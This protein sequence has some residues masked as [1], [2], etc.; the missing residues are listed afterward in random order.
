MEANNQ[1]NATEFVDIILD[2]DSEVTSSLHPID[3]S[4]DQTINEIK[5]ACTLEEPPISSHV[6]EPLTFRDA[7]DIVTTERAIPGKRVAMLFGINYIKSPQARLNGCI[8]DTYNVA[9]ML[10]TPRFAFDEVTVY[11]D[12]K[13]PAQVTMLGLVRNLQN[14]ALRSWSENLS[15]VWIH[16]S[17]HGTSV[18]DR[19]SDERDGKDEAWC[20]SD[21]LTAGVLKD[22]QLSLLL[23]R[24]NPA[25]KVVLVSD[26]CHSGTIADLAYFWVSRNVKLDEKITYPCRAPIVMISGCDDNDTSADAYMADASGIVRPQGALTNCFIRAVNEAPERALSDVFYLVERVRALLAQGRFKQVPQLT[27]SYDLRKDAKLLV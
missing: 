5:D 4:T 3:S 15:L 17:G 16:F 23:S 6:F 20:P 24:I 25:T 12:D 22:D 10:R 1:V 13:T 21:F 8:N 18:A 26:C 27:S 14:L 7:S 11:E 9:N 2:G 19:N